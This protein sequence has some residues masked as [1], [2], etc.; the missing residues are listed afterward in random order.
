MSILLNED[1]M[2]FGEAARRLV[3]ATGDKATLLRLL[4]TPGAWDEGFWRA[5]VRDGWS[6]M[7]VPGA[8]GGLGGSLV[9]LGQLAQ[10]AGAGPVGAPFLAGGAVV[11]RALAGGDGGG[12]PERIVAGVPV[13]LAFGEGCE[14]LPAAPVVRLA[15]GRLHGVKHGV[16][17]GLGA[18]AA[19]VWASGER[20]PVLALAEL[21]DA[22]TRTAIRGFDAS[23]LNA[24]LHFDGAPARVVAADVRELMAMWATLVAFE[25]VGG[26]EALLFTARDYA[27]TRRAFGQPIGAFQSVKHRIAELY[28]LVEIAKANCLHAAACD[29]TAEFVRAA[30]AARLSA[31]EAYDTAARD[32]VQIHGG[33]GT[34]WEGGLHLHMRRARSLAAECGNALLW[35]DW[36]VDEL[37]GEVA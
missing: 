37:A 22:V 29:G 1:Q 24:D 17:G 11:A 2:A 21:G 13:A 32:C 33:L 6:A 31:T 12:W 4:E 19:L 25:Q 28:G 20:G 35:E 3:A 23:R 10:A 5:A 16:V 7:G 30:A 26:V 9:D 15:D 14:V 34:T 27:L 18:A 8:F 36:L